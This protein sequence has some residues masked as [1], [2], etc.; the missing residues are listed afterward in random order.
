MTGAEGELFLIATP[1]G[2]LADITLRALETLR[3][4]DLVAA[5][6]TRTA[7][8]LFSRYQIATPLVALHDN[9]SVRR[10]EELLKRLQDGERI[11]VIS[12]AGTPGVSDPGY[13]LI[14][15]AAA[16]AIRITPLPGACAAVA[17]LS[18]SALA[19]DAFYF[20]GFLPVRPGPCRRRLESLQEIEATLIFYESPRR[21]NRALSLLEEVLGD[22]PACVAREL[23]K[24]HEEFLRY[25]LSHLRV[26]GAEREW[27]GEITLLVA[28]CDL[29]LRNRDPEM[30]ADEEARL[31]ARLA[32]PGF[33]GERSTRD[34]VQSLTAEFPLLKRRR[35]YEIVLSVS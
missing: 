28:G 12:E 17:A 21:L 5:E 26:L 13:R 32:D 10:L 19:L 11:G 20:A 18:A 33:A 6:D 14:Q 22:R 25:P 4:V 3:M 16:A 24:I 35:I 15:L 2:N 27:R 23:T 9:T 29:E 8:K 34:L 30:M 31:Q 7:R 1:I